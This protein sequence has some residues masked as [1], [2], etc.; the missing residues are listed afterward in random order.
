MATFPSRR[1]LLSCLGVVVLEATARSADAQSAADVT[2]PIQQFYQALL[3][4]MKAG[5]TTPFTQRFATLAPVLEK[6]F[7]LP[8]ILRAAV[9]L[10]WSSF[11]P[12]QQQDVLTAFRRYTVATW[13][14][15]FD[16][17]DG[18]Q[19]SILPALRRAGSAEVVQTKVVKRTGGANVIDYVM[20]Q[21][22]GPWRVAD[23]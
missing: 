18:Q 16:S 22:S 19:L 2:A 20:R 4:I 17:Y 23:V 13:V 21:A 15:N 10:G 7:D 11:Q 6:S 5:R 8:A 12:A 3:A 9:G 14:S 1:R